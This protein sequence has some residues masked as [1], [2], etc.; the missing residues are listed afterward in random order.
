MITGILSG[1]GGVGKTTVTVNLGMAMHKLGSNIVILDGDMKNPNLGI[2]LG[3]LKYNTTLQEVIKKKSSLLK[4]L[5]IHETG[6]RFIPAHLSLNFL[7]TNPTKLKNFL[8]DIPYD[9]MIDSPPGL[10]KES[11]SILECCDKVY[12]VSEPLLPDITDCMKTLEVAKELKIKVGG[13]ILNK[14]RNKN[15]ELGKEEIEACTDTKVISTIPFDENV[16]AGLSMKNPVV[17]YKPLSK[18]KCIS[19]CFHFTLLNV[20]S[21]LCNEIGNF[22]GNTWAVRRNC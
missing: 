17:H 22:M 20:T 13:I 1:K 2:H 4:A 19:H 21:A 10:C 12:I 16:I 18:A 5:C 3:V 15:Y 9:L 8:K 7:G 6:L 11:L 14:V